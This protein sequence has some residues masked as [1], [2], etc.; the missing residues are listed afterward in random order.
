MFIFSLVNFSRVKMSGLVLSANV[1]GYM[2][3]LEA[4]DKTDLPRIKAAFFKVNEKAMILNAV[5]QQ[6]QDLSKHPG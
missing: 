6:K 4:A 3:L 1:K 5:L 2:N